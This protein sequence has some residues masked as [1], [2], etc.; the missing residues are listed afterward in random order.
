M[1]I[2]KLSDL[3]DLLLC[4]LILILWHGLKFCSSFIKSNVVLVFVE[5]RSHDGYLILFLIIFS[6][7]VFHSLLLNWLLFSLNY[8]EIERCDLLLGS[9]YLV[10]V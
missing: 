5:F 4:D 8:T 10:N 9:F 2:Q 6:L 3:V 7:I 1:I